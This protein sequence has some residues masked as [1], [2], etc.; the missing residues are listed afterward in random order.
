M[1]HVN[2]FLSSCGGER[3]YFI[4][5]AGN[6]T[7]VS[8]GAVAQ[9]EHRRFRDFKVVG[10]SSLSSEDTP[11]PW[12]AGWYCGYPDKTDT[13]RPDALQVCPVW[14]YPEAGAALRETAAAMVV[15]DAVTGGAATLFVM[16]SQEDKR[17]TWP[18]EGPDARIDDL[19]ARG[20]VSFRGICGTD[21]SCVD[22]LAKLTTDGTSSPVPEILYQET[23]ADV[24]EPS[25]RSRGFHNQYHLGFTSG[26][27]GYFL[28][29]ECVDTSG[30]SLACG[31]TQGM[32]SRFCVG[33][34]SPVQFNGY[35][36][37][38]VLCDGRT[39]IVSAGTYVIEGAMT[40]AVLAAT[41]GPDEAPEDFALC[42]FP[43]ISSSDSVDAS[44]DLIAD[45]HFSSDWNCGKKAKTLTNKPYAMGQQGIGP[46]RV[47]WK[48]G[49][50]NK[51]QFS[52]LITDVVH[53]RAAVYIGSAGGGALRIEVPVYGSGLGTIIPVVPDTDT[54]ADGSAVVALQYGE[55]EEALFV[56]TSTTILKYPIGDLCESRQ[57]CTSCVSDGIYCGW[58]TLTSKCTVRARCPGARI[59]VVDRSSSLA[60]K[61]W[62][63]PNASSM[64]PRL[65]V[66][67][68]TTLAVGENIAFTMDTAGL[69]QPT[70]TAY[71]YYCQVGGNLSDY[72]T[73]LA[74][75]N[76]TGGL[77]CASNF[78]VSEI[79]TH[80]KLI[81]VVVLYGSTI[82]DAIVV[83]TGEILTMAVYSCSFLS[84]QGCSVCV[85]S[86]YNCHWCPVTASCES[87]DSCSV[88]VS[89]ISLCPDTTGTDPN[90]FPLRKGNEVS[91][92][93]VITAVNL[94]VAIPD[95]LAYKCRFSD[96]VTR[97][98]LGIV[99]ATN[100]TSTEVVCNVPDNFDS[101]IAASSTIVASD[102]GT[103]VR[104]VE[105]LINDVSVGFGGGDTRQ[106]VTV[107][108]CE[109]RARKSG[110][111]A[112]IG[113]DCSFCISQESTDYGCGWC[114]NPMNGDDACTLTHRCT[115]GKWNDDS[116]SVCPSPDI[117]VIEPLT[118]PF[119]GGTLVT[120]KGENLGRSSSDILSVHITGIEATVVEFDVKN[121][122][123]FA[124]TPLNIPTSTAPGP[125][126]IKY[127][128]G[129]GEDGNQPR[130]IMSRS[131]FQFV[132]PVIFSTS[133]KVGLE[134]GGTIVSIVGKYLTSGAKS[135]VAVD[136][137]LCIV[138]YFDQEHLKLDG[139]EE[140]SDDLTSDECPEQSS[141][142]GMSLV[143]SAAGCHCSQNVQ[144]DSSLCLTRCCKASV[145]SSC[146]RCL[147]NG[148]CASERTE[149][150][151]RCIV[152]TREYSFS[153]GITR[154]P[155]G[156]ICLQIDG[157][158]G[159][160]NCVKL[161]NET[162]PYFTIVD[163]PI[164]KTVEP[165][166]VRV[167]GGIKI[168]AHGIRTN[169]ARNPS[170]T[171]YLVEQDDFGGE[172]LR[173]LP[174]S[175][176]GR[177]SG[178]Q[179]CSYLETKA[180]CERTGVFGSLP[181]VWK[182][183]TGQ[184]CRLILSDEHAMPGSCVYNSIGTTITCKSSPVN[185]TMYRKPPHN[186]RLSYR[187]NVS[188][189]GNPLNQ[190]SRHCV[191]FVVKS[192]QV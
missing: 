22:S 191:F 7:F 25:A 58:C 190:S 120:I 128:T 108:D 84:P 11:S 171:S 73:I 178:F 48:A 33:N 164:L 160:S 78:S 118:A 107:F 166:K 172:V 36:K 121:R 47:L 12:P 89:D 63:S 39:A 142:P 136:G 37:T 91:E 85:A 98:V 159:G 114:S 57:N 66:I 45:L 181:G 116:I 69:P 165:L 124:L 137:H 24:V 131:H 21:V 158:I 38:K 132:S 153:S 76:S 155:V 53:G 44:F 77:S 6:G 62:V 40:L 103:V 189:S 92:T 183:K 67:Q 71:S 26:I 115:S 3:V 162:L 17:D 64:C 129:G 130:S 105:V 151:L 10:R 134:S 80:E 31:Q 14:R 95:E 94:P 68:P 135:Q 83:A 109:A 138:T 167:S 101:G 4:T 32:I 5:P 170:L 148:E 150:A 56:L 169:I 96:A 152:Q 13:E 97:S 157:M 82:G 144:C 192:M 65:N 88:V 187:F 27:Y 52:G 42:I 186:I 87:D 141:L 43:I 60:T 154:T 149:T 15:P 102:T 123:I 16:G 20:L 111:G 28:F 79:D 125:V 180:G 188:S 113:Q 122:V 61:H 119:T 179:T 19:V 55:V 9:C 184:C 1:C 117:T 139:E 2:K 156:A 176:T 127:S 41:R 174:D 8:C 147:K 112:S 29:E 49:I 81:E 173:E 185:S 143:T 106:N 35:V 99:H 100:V 168:T 72:P 54:M 23:L 133:P 93:I 70:S 146:N 46:G 30:G 182:A 51:K 110:T 50:G 90:I 177:T 75:I 126:E 18:V 140:L 86:M 104:S 59:A 163:D 161:E 145:D 34:E 175:V 74:N